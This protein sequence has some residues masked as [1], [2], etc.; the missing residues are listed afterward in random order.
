MVQHAIL[1][2]DIQDTQ[3]FFQ[4]HY[5]SFPVFCITQH[6]SLIPLQPLVL[7]DYE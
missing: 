5:G 3:I 4:I 1:K 6:F 2:Y 7:L